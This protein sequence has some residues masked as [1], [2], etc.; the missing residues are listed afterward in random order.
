M[1]RGSSP[2][3]T[4]L[5]LAISRAVGDQIPARGITELA[6]RAGIDRRHFTRLVAGERTWYLTELEL[7]CDA[8]G[9]DIVEVIADAR[10]SVE[11]VNLDDRRVVTPGREDIQAVAESRDGNDEGDYEGA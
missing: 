9:L 8:L 6:R 7:A 2:L 11:V 10:R 3:P 5:S 1:P 4:P